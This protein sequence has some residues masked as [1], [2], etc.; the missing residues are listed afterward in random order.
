MGLG[1]HLSCLDCKKESKDVEF[2]LAKTYHL[3][4]TPGDYDALKENWFP[5]LFKHSGHR[6]EVRDELGNET[7]PTKIDVEYFNT[8]KPPKK[9]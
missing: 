3:K 8:G 5:F 1:Y 6:I 9:K 7:D 4:T 2:S